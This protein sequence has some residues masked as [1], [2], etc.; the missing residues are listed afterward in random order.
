M[1]EKNIDYF[2]VS[3]LAMKAMDFIQF[4]L[5]REFLDEDMILADEWAINEFKRAPNEWKKIALILENLPQ[6]SFNG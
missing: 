2:H 1:N 6:G 4:G 3:L 5:K